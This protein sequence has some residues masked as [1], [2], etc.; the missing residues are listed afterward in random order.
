MYTSVYQ[1][2]T[3]QHRQRAAVY[4][5]VTYHKESRNPASAAQDSA[6]NC[7][8]RP[9]L[10]ARTVAPSTLCPASSMTSDLCPLPHYITRNLNQFS[11]LPFTLRYSSPLVPLSSSS[12]LRR[13]LVLQSPFTRR[14]GSTKCPHPTQIV[15]CTTPSTPSSLSQD[16]SESDP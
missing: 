1:H 3:T 10:C 16:P 11:P 4:N 6:C 9:V 12:D 2:N 7:R 13:I 14:I 5:R 8:T 15:W